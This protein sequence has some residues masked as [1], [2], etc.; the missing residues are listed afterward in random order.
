MYGNQKKQLV[1]PYYRGFSWLRFASPVSITRQG[2]TITNVLL[3]V[4]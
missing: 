1:N 4:W 2:K 3:N